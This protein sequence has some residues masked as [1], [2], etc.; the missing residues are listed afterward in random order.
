MSESKI[1]TY[2]RI[3]NDLRARIL[4]GKL[5]PGQ[6]VPSENTLVDEYTTT[7]PTV[8]KG[9]ALLKAEGLVVSRQGARAIVRPRPRVQMLSTG[10][11]FRHRQ[12][13]GK[14]NFNAEVIA[15][16]GVPEQKILSVEVVSA[17]GEIAERLGVPA[18]ALVIVRRR[19][20]LVNDEP[21]QFVDG[22]YPEAV[23]RGT[24][25]ERP[26]R[27]RGGVTGLIKDPNGPIGK[28]ITQFVEDLD[29]RMP[30]PEETDALRIPPGVPL[31]RV[32]RTAHVSDGTIVEVLDSRVPC[33]RHTF[34]YVIDVP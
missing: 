32:F 19:L 34:R 17:P 3:A 7:R 9:I 24:A 20:F 28:R 2:R 1:P 27:I 4:A 8:R 11:N 22:Y 29:V 31:A 21:M 16:G 33:D 12:E 13:S 6:E 30:T 26:Q 14:S 25:V 18:G 5:S 23:F 15:Q 10:A